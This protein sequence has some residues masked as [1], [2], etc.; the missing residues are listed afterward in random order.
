MLSGVHPMAPRTT[1]DR[2][3]A[4]DILALQVLLGWTFGVAGTT[5]VAGAILLAA[6]LFHRRSGAARVD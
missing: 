5:V 1:G 2:I 3:G 6:D 4:M